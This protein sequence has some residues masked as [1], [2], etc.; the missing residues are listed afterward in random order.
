MTH[1]LTV[2]DSEWDGGTFRRWQPIEEQAEDPDGEDRDEIGHPP[3]LGHFGWFYLFVCR[4]C[5]GFPTRAVTA[6]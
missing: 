2:A 4:N 3:D 6:R 5:D 1:L